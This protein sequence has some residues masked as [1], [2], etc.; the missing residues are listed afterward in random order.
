[1]TVLI[2]FLLLFLLGR[3]LLSADLRGKL[4]SLTLCALFFG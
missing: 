4:F 1:M 2:L 3:S